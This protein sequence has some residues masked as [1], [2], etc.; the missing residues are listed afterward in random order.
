MKKLLILLFLLASSAAR[1]QQPIISENQR[2]A[3]EKLLNTRPKE[4][5]EKMVFDFATGKITSFS[6]TVKNVFSDQLYPL[7]KTHIELNKRIT[8]VE[9]G[10]WTQKNALI[11]TLG[12]EVDW[13]TFILVIITGL[14]TALIIYQQNWSWVWQG[15]AAVIF[16]ALIVVILVMFSAIFV[17]ALNLYMP[18]NV[19]MVG[20]GIIYYMF[21]QPGGLAILLLLTLRVFKR[22]NYS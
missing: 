17:F 16:G 7:P 10:R 15:I 12:S 13:F 20:H 1:A 6:D 14:I 22:E 4:I 3:L 2:E 8:T 18:D 21:L 11:E 19:D 5:S 9:N